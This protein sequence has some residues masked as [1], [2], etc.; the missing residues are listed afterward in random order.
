[1]LVAAYGCEDVT[2]DF[3]PLGPGRV[4][5][6]RVRSGDTEIGFESISVLEQLPSRE[7][8]VARYKVQEP[9]A[10][11]IW[12]KD[13]RTVLRA[14]DGLVTTVLQHPPFVGS[15]WTDRAP[16]GS[17]V[18]CTV[19]RREAVETSAGVFKNCL[20]VRREA[21]DRSSIVTQWF[22]PDVGLVKWKVERPNRPTFEWELESSSTGER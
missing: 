1:M 18:Y 12:T 7:P 4:W 5:M 13:G 19:L 8:G 21:E 15:G 16:D 11:A 22:A 20:V 14:A 9:G 2:R 3:L 10:V 17:S 6:Y